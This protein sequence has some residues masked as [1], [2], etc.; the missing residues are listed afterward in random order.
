[1]RLESSFTSLL[2]STKVLDWS[3]EFGVYS[4]KKAYR[5]KWGESGEAV[6]HNVRT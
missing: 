4:Q 3:K 2:C 5:S 1:M 6:G